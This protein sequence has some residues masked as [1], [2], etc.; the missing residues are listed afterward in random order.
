MTRWR[1]V[2]ISPELG[3]TLTLD[4][5]DPELVARVEESAKAQGITLQRIDESWP[6]PSEEAWKAD[7]PDWP[8]P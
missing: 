1:W 3:L 7:T 8:E 2:T 6:Q 5:D 4:S